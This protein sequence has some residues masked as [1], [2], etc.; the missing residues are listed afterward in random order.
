MSFKRSL[1][2]KGSP[3][4]IIK[5]RPG[6]GTNEIDLRDEFERLIYGGPSDLAHG[7]KLLIRK[8]DRD[9]NNKLKPCP[10][11]SNITYEPDAESSC[12]YCLGEG[13]FWK[14]EWTTGYS[15]YVGA[16]G[17]NSNRVREM[18]PGSI[19]ADYRIFYLR[20]D[21]ILSYKD[22]IVDVKLDSEGEPSVP[23]VR[24]SIYKPQTINRFR[25]DNGRTE[26]IAVF[27]NEKDAIRLDD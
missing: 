6:T 19:R 4:G 21:T 9:E 1:Y 24:E 23:Y 14:E 18:T 20:Y 27:C 12:P 16:D 10:C 15:T 3:K 7:R 13:Y 17:G 11:V 22:K 8:M 25:S 2:P 26:Y 5:D